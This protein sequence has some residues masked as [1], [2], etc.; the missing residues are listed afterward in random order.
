MAVIAAVHAD[1]VSADSTD[2]GEIAGLYDVL[3]RIDPSLNHEICHML[4]LS[5]DKAAV[6]AQ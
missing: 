4:D 1:A 6:A 3:L 2:W 5:T